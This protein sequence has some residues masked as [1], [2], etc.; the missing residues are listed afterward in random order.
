MNSLFAQAGQANNVDPNLA[1]AVSAVESS[2]DPNATSPTGAHGLMQLEPGTAS[3]MGV[4]DSSDAGQNIN[5]GTKYLSKMLTQFGN[6]PDAL[7]HYNAGPNRNVNNPETQAYVGKVQAAYQDILRA[8]GIKVAQADTGNATDA[9]SAPGSAPI[10]GRPSD[11]QMMQMLTGGSGSSPPPA[12]SSAAAPG[13]LPSAAPIPG[14]PDDATMM[15]MLTGSG[16]PPQAAGGSGAPSATL[17][18]PQTPPPSTPPGAPSA[19]P[20][21]AFATVAPHPAPD[22]SGVTTTSAMP[23]TTASSSSKRHRLMGQPMLRRQS[24]SA[25]Q[26]RSGRRWRS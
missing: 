17:A 1:A 26:P 22:G 3:D 15:Q 13:N 16:S 18:P 12:S 10:P 2:Y 11:D 7:M 25:G 6:V 23:I 24:L 9:G 8:G 21:A 20:P 4:K 5:G 19:A 14:R